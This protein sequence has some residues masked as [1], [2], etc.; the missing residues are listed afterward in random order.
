MV[1]VSTSLQVSVRLLN[2][3]SVVLDPASGAPQDPLGVDALLDTLLG[4]M[5][6]VGNVSGQHISQVRG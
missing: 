5:K 3:Q 4:V 1:M 2:G 6:D